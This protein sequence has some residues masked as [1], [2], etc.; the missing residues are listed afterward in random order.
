MLFYNSCLTL[1]WQAMLKKTLAV[2]AMVIMIGTLT[3]CW[4][5]VDYSKPAI[6]AD[7][8]GEDSFISVANKTGALSAYLKMRRKE[9]FIDPAPQHAVDKMAQPIILSQINSPNDTPQLTW[10]GHATVLVQHAG[11]NFLT[12]PHLS[13]YAS[14]IP[15]MGPKRL[16]PPALT[17]DQLPEIDFVLI[18]H[19]HYDHLDHKTVK[20]IGNSSTW[21][22][23]L[24]LKQWLLKRDISEDK[25][26][27]LDWWQSYA[28][29]DQVSITATPSQHWSKRTPFDTNKSLWASWHIDI[30]GFKTWFAGDT[31]YNEAEFKKIGQQ[32][33]PH[34]LA[35]IPIGAYAPRYFMLP[36][37]VD[38]QQAVKSH[39]DVKSK[40]SVGI[41]WGTFQL[42]HEPYSE[43]RLLLEES[44]QSIEPEYPFVTM[45]IGQTQVLKYF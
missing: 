18:S 25:I 1:S 22:V 31:G 39:I 27:E 5:S 23:P 4:R 9:G 7:H 38:P 13:D 40:H 29:T 12:D 21:L 2:V 26:I 44:I 32:L 6:T 8:H 14:P 43:P 35:L 10:L 20:Q 17:I 28:Y 15:F 45:K 34:D 11:V 16:I 30:K 19:N 42:T 24:G 37:H 33:G 3:A 41:H 36:M